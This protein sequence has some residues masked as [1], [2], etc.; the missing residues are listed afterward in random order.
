MRLN[1]AG[2]SVLAT[3]AVAAAVLAT[4]ATAQAAEQNWSALLCHEHDDDA[5]DH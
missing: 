4:P 1:K 3:M 2:A 5:G